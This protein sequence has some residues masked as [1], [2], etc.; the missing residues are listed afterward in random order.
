MG[1]WSMHLSFSE[2]VLEPW[3]MKIQYGYLNFHPQP[4][5]KALKHLKKLKLHEVKFTCIFFSSFSK[6]FRVM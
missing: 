5:I 2:S 1:T 6:C 3:I 4:A